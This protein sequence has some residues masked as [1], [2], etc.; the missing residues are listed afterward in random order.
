MKFEVKEF[1]VD[2]IMNV[3]SLNKGKNVSWNTKSK[4]H[5]NQ[6]FGIISGEGN[7]ISHSNN[8]VKSQNGGNEQTSS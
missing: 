1:K 5:E 7:S 8:I 3:S 6:G 4:Q 2:I